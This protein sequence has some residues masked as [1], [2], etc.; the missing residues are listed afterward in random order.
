MLEDTSNY[1]EI[2]KNHEPVDLSMAESWLI[3][4]E[5]LAICKPSIEEYFDGYVSPG[6]HFISAQSTTDTEDPRSVFPCLQI[7]GAILA[8]WS[9]LPTFSTIISIPS[10]QSSQL[11]LLWNVCDEGTVC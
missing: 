2:G 7:S 3:R 1:T 6:F 9:S 5:V 10:Y 4:E 11:T 8:F